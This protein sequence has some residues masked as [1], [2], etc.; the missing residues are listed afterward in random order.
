MGTSEQPT[1][2]YLFGAGATQACVEALDS[3]YGILMRDLNEELT[4]R[5]GALVR[6]GPYSDHRGLQTLVNSVIDEDTDIEHLITFLDDSPS[7]LHREFADMVRDVF[8]EVL[9]NRLRQIDTDLEG[10]PANL[11]TALFDMYNIEGFPEVLGGC[12]TLNYDLYIEEAIAH[13]DDRDVSYG[14]ELDQKSSDHGNIELIKLHGSFGWEDAW[15]VRRADAEHPLWIPPGIQKA[16]EIYPFNLLWGRAREL[17]DC[18]VLRVVGC[19]LG[20][21]DWDLISLLFTTRHVN[22]K[23][24]PYQVEMID[25]PHQAFHVQD[26]FPYLDVRSILEVE[27]IGSQLIGELSGGKPKTL[28]DFEPEKRQEF[29][30]SIGSKNWFLLWLKHKAEAIYTDPEID[31]IDTDLGAIQALLEGRL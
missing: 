10:T 14:I 2:V 20:P 13:F 17:L 15:P 8:E 23:R 16:K 29:L 27:P 1:V 19:Q 25:A 26:D 28:D 18:D 30:S 5:L 6:D 22:E 7:A 21:N 31:T 24:G 11:Y 3:P 9:R 12:L 4:K